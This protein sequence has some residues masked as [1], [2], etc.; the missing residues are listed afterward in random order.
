MTTKRQNALI[1]MPIAMG[2]L[3][4]L[5][6][7]LIIVS[8]CRSNQRKKRA[9]LSPRRS[10]SLRSSLEDH[11]SPVYN[12]KMIA[13]SIY[14]IVFT[15]V[16]AMFGDLFKPRDTDTPGAGRWTRDNL[17][18]F[19]PRI[20]FSLG[21]WMFC[22]WCMAECLLCADHSIQRPRCILGAIFR[23]HCSFD[24]FRV[25]FWD[26]SDFIDPWFHESHNPFYM[27]CCAISIVL[28]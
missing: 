2:S 13:M 18:L 11:T 6:S 27:L 25:L 10:S 14:D 1:Y 7:S 28:L 12:R 4:L 23:T 16:S 19:S 24:C 3:S 8:I 15:F 22:I 9:N 20:L 21:I 5:G 17:H 26:R